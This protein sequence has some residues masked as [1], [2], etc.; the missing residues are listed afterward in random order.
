MHLCVE[1]R[2]DKD[3]VSYNLSFSHG[4]VEY[5][6]QKHASIEQLLEEGDQLMYQHKKH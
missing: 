4:V 5:D 2:K 1:F 6:P 3:P